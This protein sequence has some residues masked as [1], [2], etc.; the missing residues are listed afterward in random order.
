MVARADAAA[1]ITIEFEELR[2]DDALIHFVGPVY[3]VDGFIFTASVLPERAIL[4]GSTRSARRHL[5]RDD[6]YTPFGGKRS[7][8]P[9]RTLIERLWQLR[10]GTGKVLSCGLTQE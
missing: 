1:P 7:G 4:P 2:V 3:A 8:P 5:M 9:A 6:T 10:S